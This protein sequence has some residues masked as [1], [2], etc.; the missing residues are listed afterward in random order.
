[1]RVFPASQARRA[2]P[3]AGPGWEVC[4]E[5]DFT[6]LPTQSFSNGDNLVAGIPFVASNSG[7]AS[8]F[9]ITNGTGLQIEPDT[10]SVFNATTRDAPIVEMKLIDLIGNW[11]VGDRIF[12]Q[13]HVDQPTLDD[14]GQ[15]Y[16]IQIGAGN[17]AND[18]LVCMYDVVYTGSAL[19]ERA[20]RYLVSTVAAQTAS[21]TTQP[22]FM[23]LNYRP[24]NCDA[25]R[26]AL[27]DCID[28][29][30]FPNPRDMTIAFYRT[31]IW[32]GNWATTDYTDPE[33]DLV[34]LWAQMESATNAFTITFMG[35]RVLVQRWGS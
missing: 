31:N 8:T 30:V 1:M 6:A 10:G 27:D 24:A 34:R 9:G 16:G 28:G 20:A 21:L 12:F 23:G 26:A 4:C 17:R 3:P 11:Q 2:W 18:D 32:T 25:H 19:N 15:A 14:D 33:T 7:N 5:L 29:N 35:L 22:D 13:V